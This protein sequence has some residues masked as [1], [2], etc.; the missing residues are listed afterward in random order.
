MYKVCIV[1]AGFVGL[2]LALSLTKRGQHVIAIEKDLNVVN[3]LR[4]G[5]VRFDEP[6]LLSYLS[7]ATS[8]GLFEVFSP[9]E[10]IEILK[11]C[12]VFI[13]TVGK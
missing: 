4:A 12:N 13:L 1:G 2:T 11:E 6:E 9:E 3:E 5:Y 7:D 8:K 10:N